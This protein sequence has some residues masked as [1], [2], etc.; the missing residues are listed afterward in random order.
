MWWKTDLKWENDQKQRDK[1]DK[2]P[3]AREGAGWCGRGER[4]E[5]RAPTFT[6]INTL[7]A[8]NADSAHAEGTPAAMQK[9]PSAR[10]KMQRAHSYNC[11]LTG[12]EWFHSGT[13]VSLWDTGES[14]CLWRQQRGMWGPSLCEG[15]SWVKDHTCLDAS[16]SLCCALKL[17]THFCRICFSVL[18]YANCSSLATLEGRNGALRESEE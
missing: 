1:I 15:C 12:H 18:K 7:G 16:P 2:W 4:A 6:I 17:L 8:I 10:F 9:S 3:R 14:F 11:S 5:S 13:A